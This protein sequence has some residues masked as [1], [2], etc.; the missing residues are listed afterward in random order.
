LIARFELDEAQDAAAAIAVTSAPVKTRRRPAKTTP[1]LKTLSQR[2]P[3]AA[4][5]PAWSEF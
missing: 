2:Q 4:M 3:A 1:A 5:A